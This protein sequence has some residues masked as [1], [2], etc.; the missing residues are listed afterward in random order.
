MSLF[1][2]LACSSPALAATATPRYGGTLKLLWDQG[3]GAY[4]GYNPEKHF[5]S[6]AHTIWCFERLV[7]V[8]D[9]GK[10][11][12]WLVTDWKI[13][14]DKLTAT[15]KL[16]QGV[17]FH[18]GTD[19]NA[20]AVVWN[21]Q[22]A[23]DTKLSYFATWISAEAID[24]YTVLLKL[25]SYTN[26]FTTS[27]ARIDIL[28]PTA[29]K[30]KGEDW[31]N[32]NPVGTGPFKFVSFEKDKSLKFTRNENY[33][34]KGLPYLDAVEYMYIADKMTR[35]MA[36]MSGQ[37]HIAYEL[38]GQQRL[39]LEAKGFKPAPPPN[40]GGTVI[41]IDFDSK[42]KD[43]P[44][45]KIKVRE[46]VS[47]ALDRDAICA[48]RG[49]GMWEPTEQF[50]AKGAM[51]Y[52]A[53]LPKRGYNP[54][55][56]KQLLTEAG[57]GSGIKAKMI[58]DPQSV[59]R[60]L[61]VLVQDYLKKVGIMIDLDYVDA[62]AFNQVRYQTGWTNGMLINGT[63][64]SPNFAYRMNQF[65]SKRGVTSHSSWVSDEFDKAVDEALKTLEPE[66]ALMQ[67][68]GKMFVEGLFQVPIHTAPVGPQPI[69]QP[70]VVNDHGI[71]KQQEWMFM[72]PETCWLSK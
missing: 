9:T 48:A 61:T 32:K 35:Q 3:P 14:L 54:E 49:F 67:K 58:V 59:D 8:T 4:L 71:H 18:D 19:F 12:P 41:V 27:L 53:D 33:W 46:A 43:S 57:C 6:L 2:L 17:K 36:F 44:F 15:L 42:H 64:G 68:I 72:T 25:K 24:H 60:D 38:K 39:D 66:E 31:A 1:F 10:A 47:L 7:R 45:S 50:T 20:E 21:M 65:C 29:V 70:N 13:D 56:A 40:Y 23:I 63:S 55:K 5:L 16:R 28:S 30:T 52:V 62:A 34:Q 26:M 69:L 11:V 51:G 37:G 22:R